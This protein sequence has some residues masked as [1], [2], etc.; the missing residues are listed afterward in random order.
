MTIYSLDIPEVVRDELYA[1]DYSVAERFVKKLRKILHN[2][3][4]PK[5]KLRGLPNCYKIKLRDDGIRGVYQV[6]DQEITVLLIAVGKRDKS[7]VYE[8]AK[9]RL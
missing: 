8:T 6:H 2:P 7:A 1:L 3:H 9:D 4:V 5:N